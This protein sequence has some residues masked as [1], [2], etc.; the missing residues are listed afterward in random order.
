MCDLAC[1]TISSASLSLHSTLFANSAIFNLALQMSNL[2]F[3]SFMC[4]QVNSFRP[5][6]SLDGTYSNCADQEQTAQDAVSDPGL[7]CLL[8][9]VSMQKPG[10]VAQSVARLTQETEVSD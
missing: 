7:D 4:N 2:L 5:K 10:R 9:E 8:K 3:G 1:G 6:H